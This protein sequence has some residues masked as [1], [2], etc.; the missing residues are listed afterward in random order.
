MKC[1]THKIQMKLKNFL[2]MILEITISLIINEKHRNCL[3]VIKLYHH[4]LHSHKCENIIKLNSLQIKKN[5]N[6]LLTFKTV[7]H[8]IQRKFCLIKNMW[9]WENLIGLLY[10]WLKMYHE[11][12]HWESKCRKL[13][14]I[15]KMP[16]MKF[17][18]KDW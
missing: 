3:K 5:V 8:I 9:R 14:Q 4:F 1:E 11:L 16:I 18:L 12:T 6:L 7:L 2:I 13:Q 17:L 15:I 10:L